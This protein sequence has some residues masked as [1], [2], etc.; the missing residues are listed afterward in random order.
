M[1]RLAASAPL[2]QHVL[3][4]RSNSEDAESKKEEEEEE[5]VVI[6]D[7]DDDDNEE[8]NNKASGISPLV[9]AYAARLGNEAD[10]AR[11]RACKETSSSS[12]AEAFYSRLATLQALHSYGYYMN[13]LALSS[14]V[15]QYQ[16]HQLASHL[17]TPSSP[18]SNN[19]THSPSSSLLSPPQFA[20]H[21]PTTSSASSSCSASPSSAS[22][23]H[24]HHIRATYLLLPA[25]RRS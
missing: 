18:T 5:D 8:N 10:Y 14:L 16:Q 24:H 3:V 17:Q 22:T 19:I 11:Y 1:H 6:D 21:S 25:R 20:Q 9:S 15:S 7:D 12:L 13:P 2:V 23:K 4:R